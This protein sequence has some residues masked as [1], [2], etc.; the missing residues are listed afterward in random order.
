[1]YSWLSEL[2]SLTLSRSLFVQASI[3]RIMK[4]RK[5]LQHNTLITE[6]VEQLKSR[7]P[8]EIPMIKTSIDGLIEKEYLERI[9]DKRGWYRY[10][11]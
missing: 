2:S 4:M 8:P 5:E 3:V 9:A 6:V 11:A 1:M 10:L 7:F